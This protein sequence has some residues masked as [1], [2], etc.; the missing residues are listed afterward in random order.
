MFSHYRTSK[1]SK[2]PHD[3]INE[4]IDHYEIQLHVNKDIT[5]Q[6]II[7]FGG[8]FTESAAFTLSNVSDSK[9]EKVLTSYFDKVE[10]LNYTIGRV[11][12][13]SCDFSLG[14][15]TY[16]EDNDI[17]LKTFDISRELKYVIPMIKDAER[18]AGH[19]IKLLASPWSPPAWMKSNKEMNNGGYLLPEY[20]ETW[21]R[22]YVKFIDAFK[23]NDL[24]IEYITVQN[25]PAAVQVW[26]SCIYTAEEERDFVKDYLGP[27]LHEK[28]PDVKILIWD[29]NRD[30]IVHRADT[31]LKSKEAREHVWGTGLHWYVSEAFENLTKVHDLHPDKHILFTEGCIEGGVHL[32]DHTTGERYA[33]NMIGDFNNY[34]EGYLDWNLTLNEQGGPNHVGNYCDAP[35]ITDTIKK[36]IIFNSSYYYIGHFSKYV[37]PNSKRIFSNLESDE[38]KHVSFLTPENEVV[39]IILNQTENKYNVKIN[40]ADKSKIIEVSP[41]SIS[42]I[43]ERD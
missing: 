30:I 20:Y 41:R 43:I 15:Y 26:D 40:I 32:N 7:G 21:A 10:G 37:K 24:E 9:R 18:I 6:T 23:K 16:V 22:Y 4:Q 3:V 14:N 8:A 35:I 38:L 2:K 27:I 34:C 31:V 13:H 19:K 36:E 25:E 42:T 39:T 11:H 1:Y 12:I 5:F 33:R 29:H 17:E 28:Y